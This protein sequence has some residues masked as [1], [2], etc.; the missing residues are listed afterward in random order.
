MPPGQT[1][2]LAISLIVHALDS[3]RRFGMSLLG[4]KPGPTSTI[5]Y[6]HS[7][8]ESEVGNYSRQLD[9]IG[10]YAVPFSIENPPE[11]EAGRR[12]AAVTFD[13]G[14]EDTVS[15]A[16]PELL[17]R[18]IPATVFVTAGAMGNPAAWWPS[19]SPESGRMI[20]AAD[21]WKSAQGELIRIG[22]HAL[23]HPLM[24]SL[25]RTDALQELKESRRILQMQME[26]D[27][28]TFSFPYGD[29]NE[30]LIEMCREAGYRKVFT[31]LPANAARMKEQ[32][33]VGRVK[34]EPADSPLV[35]RLKLS[36]AYNWL[37][38]AIKAKK[39]LRRICKL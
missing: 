34:V 14:F 11:F 25:E 9:M 22:S 2:K 30:E 10:Q 27:V 8:R 18:G 7:I 26:T 29:F 37:P 24:T 6:Y 4:L 13:D 38:Y 12:Y 20:A 15:N 16:I 21:T 32:Y 31:T 23:T 19:S 39:T 1:I 35:Y 5:V 33:V 36:G 28:G 17:K 3:L